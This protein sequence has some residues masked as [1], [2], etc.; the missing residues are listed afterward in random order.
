MWIHLAVACFVTGLLVHFFDKFTMTFNDAYS[1]S[2]TFRN[3]SNGDAFEDPNPLS[4]W[5]RIAWLMSY[6][7]SVN[8]YFDETEVD[9]CLVSL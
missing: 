6:P 3:E 1:V 8:A 5:P 7:N 2:V 9:G 4:P